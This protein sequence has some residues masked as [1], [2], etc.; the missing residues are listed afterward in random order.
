MR[1][2]IKVRNVGQS[3]GCDAV[4]MALNNRQIHE[5]RTF[6]YGMRAQ[7]YDAAKTWCEMHGHRVTPIQ[8]ADL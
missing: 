7:A 3:F 6:P 5:T 8:H 2:K 4:V 1:V